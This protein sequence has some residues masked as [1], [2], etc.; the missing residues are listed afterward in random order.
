M[1]VEPVIK[2]KEA[3]L[4]SKEND[5]NL[6]FAPGGVE[7]CPGK[8]ID[9]NHKTVGL[10]IGPEGGWSDEELFVAKEKSFQIVG[11]GKNV[12]RGETAVIVASFLAV[13]Y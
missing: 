5:V 6:F 9:S 4:K 3:V 2:F 11:I 7:F 8:T 10:F 1:V 12:L 13:N